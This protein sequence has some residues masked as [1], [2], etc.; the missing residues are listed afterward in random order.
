MSVLI[1][2]EAQHL[3]GK[4]GKVRN[5]QKGTVWEGEYRVVGYSLDPEDPKSGRVASLKVESVRTFP[6]TTGAQ[7]EIIPE[8]PQVVAHSLNPGWFQPNPGS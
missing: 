3:V 7:G 2:S 5:H 4:V 6:P 8:R 1:E